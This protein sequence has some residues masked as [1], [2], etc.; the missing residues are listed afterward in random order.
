MFDRTGAQRV[1]ANLSFMI[2][3]KNV[4]LVLVNDYEIPK[5]EEIEL[6]DKARRII[7]DDCNNY[8]KG[9]F[10]KNVYRIKKLRKILKQE[11][12]DLALSFLEGPNKKLIL[13]SLG[14]KIN[15]VI[16]IRCNPAAIYKSKFSYFVVNMLY[17]FSKRIVFQTQDA[18]RFFWKR[19]Q[20]KGVIINNSVN[21]L[22]FDSKY[23]G[24]SNNIVTFG[25]LEPEEKKKLLIDAFKNI[26]NMVPDSELF[27]YGSGS[28]KSCFLR[29]SNDRI[30]ILDNVTDVVSILE[31]C[32]VF[33]LCSDTEGMPNALME[34]LA[35]GV[36]SISTDCPCGGPKMLIE[37]GVNGFL[38]NC[39]D[40]KALEEDI[41]TLFS[42]KE[43]RDQFSLACKERAL[44]FHPDR[45]NKQWLSFFEEV[46]QDS[47]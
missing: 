46:I 43:L 12:P 35:V 36:P 30:H 2:V 47:F 14:L 44:L 27:I 16:S 7:L 31:Q 23:N 40:Q 24:C 37:N 42:S 10:K 39:G 21:K 1:M 17:S 20:K 38:I 29:Y 28:L 41:V 11:K 4:E 5:E 13:A 34:A 3:K 32:K 25:R 33:V 19:I 6:P 15:T 22:F 18:L 26:E 45:I 8:N 9:K